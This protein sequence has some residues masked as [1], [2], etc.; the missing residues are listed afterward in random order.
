MF[1]EM[2]Q[3]AVRHPEEL[4]FSFWRRALRRLLDGQFFFDTDHPVTDAE[5]NVTQ[6][7]N[8]RRAGT[9]WYLGHLARLRPLI[10]KSARTSP[11]A[12][13]ENSEYV[14]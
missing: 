9:A 3:A 14:S 13:Q 8:R 11:T 4:V 10:G 6:V 1:A 7:S 2:G 5:G 12:P